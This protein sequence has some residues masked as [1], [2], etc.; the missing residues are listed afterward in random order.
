MCYNRIWVLFAIFIEISS[1]V[2]AQVANGW[3]IFEGAS[4]K[5]EYIEEYGSFTSMLE[6]TKEIR[7]IEGAEI[8]LKGYYIP[9]EE[10]GIII[11]SKFPFASCFF[12]GA[13]G[14]ESIAEVRMRQKPKRRF[15]M[16]EKLTFTGR[17]HFNTS[18]WRLFSFIL[19]DA[20][21]VN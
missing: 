6:N 13:A 19:K 10:D 11:L 1:I 5:E 16:D 12:C 7:E 20:T 21:L 8:T 2:N 18:D 14:L 17:I 4:F 3:K 9:V 15:K